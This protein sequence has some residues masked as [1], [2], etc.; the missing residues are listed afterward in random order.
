VEDGQRFELVAHVLREAAQREFEAG[1]EGV[2][3]V[4]WVFAVEVGEDE[5]EVLCRGTDAAVGEFAGEEDESAGVAVY[6]FDEF[7]N[8]LRVGAGVV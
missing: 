6:G 7:N 1:V 8:F 5:A 3:A 4:A 2:L